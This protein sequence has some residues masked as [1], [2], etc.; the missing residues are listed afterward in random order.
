MTETAVKSNKKISDFQLESKN[1]NLISP[2]KDKYPK[3]VF[4]IIINE[5]CER[6]SYYGFKAVL[7]I[8]FTKFLNIESSTATALYHAFAMLCYSTTIL[9][10]MLADGYI[11]L[12]KTI[13]SLSVLYALGEIVLTLTR[14]AKQ[15]KSVNK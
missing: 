4:L 2:Q 10:A 13:I 3:I 1:D 6:F 8:Y 14:Q 5:F 7:Y 12:Y 15:K 9:G 11:G